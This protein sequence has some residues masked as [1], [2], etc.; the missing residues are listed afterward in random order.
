MHRSKSAAAIPAMSG[1]SIG[2]GGLMDQVAVFEAAEA[3]NQPEQG[4]SK[5]RQVMGHVFGVLQLT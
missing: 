3:A 4:R 5:V 1:V 2:R